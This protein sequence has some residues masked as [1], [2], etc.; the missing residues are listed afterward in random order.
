MAPLL[1]VS[2]ADIDSGIANAQKLLS[3]KYLKSYSE[4]VMI[5]TLCISRRVAMAP[6]LAV[7]REGRP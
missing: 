4:N 6:L 1:K 7:K 5:T 3:L 2:I